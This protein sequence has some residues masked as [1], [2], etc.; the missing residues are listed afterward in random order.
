MPKKAWHADCY[1]ANAMPKKKIIY[2]HFVRRAARLPF[3]QVLFCTL[4]VCVYTSQKVHYMYRCTLVYNCTL[5]GP[6]SS[7]SINPLFRHWVYAYP[8][9][10]MQTFSSQL[11][12]GSPQSSQVLGKF[13]TASDTANNP[14]SRKELF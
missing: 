7:D 5:G 2:C 4:G 1:V 8:I 13:I 6:Q 10:V 3:C 12:I 11:F 9:G 14:A